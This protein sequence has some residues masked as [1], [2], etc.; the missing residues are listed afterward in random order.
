MAFSHEYHETCSD[1][2][3]MR[4]FAHYDPVLTLVMKRN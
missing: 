4:E 2:H 3:A 1:G